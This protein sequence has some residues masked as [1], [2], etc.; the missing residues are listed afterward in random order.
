MTYKLTFGDE[1]LYYEGTLELMIKIAINL[2]HWKESPL[3]NF[4]GA[5]LIEESP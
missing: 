4:K 2:I 3:Y 5:V 1:I